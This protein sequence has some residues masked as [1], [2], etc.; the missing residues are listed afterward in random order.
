MASWR[1]LANLAGPA[2][3]RE[4][5]QAGGLVP[6]VASLVRDEPGDA[7]LHSSGSRGG[8]SG[9]SD[10]GRARH[11]EAIISGRYKAHV[12]TGKSAEADPR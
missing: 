9:L 3:N 11:P 7:G 12:T 8:D 5:D 10:R 1:G 4:M 6:R 2:R